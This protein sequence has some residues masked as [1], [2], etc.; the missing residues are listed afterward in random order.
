MTNKNVKKFTSSDDALITR[1][2]LVGITD[3][4]NR[5]FSARDE[6]PNS[7]YPDCQR[8]HSA[9]Q[10]SNR[11]RQRELFSQSLCDQRS[12][13]LRGGGRSPSRT[14]LHSQIPC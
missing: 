14:S 12:G 1:V 7:S 9:N 13:E 10:P 5:I 8:P 3:A 2:S 11:P 4:R 6:A